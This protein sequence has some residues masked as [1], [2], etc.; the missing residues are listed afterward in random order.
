MSLDS[1]LY[2]DLLCL[3]GFVFLSL[4]TEDLSRGSLLS[5]GRNE[6]TVE[7]LDRAGDGCRVR[8]PSGV[9]NAFSCCI[10]FSR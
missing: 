7:V 4:G 5:N 8:C 2:S 1:L 9:P 6:R 10:T 3:D